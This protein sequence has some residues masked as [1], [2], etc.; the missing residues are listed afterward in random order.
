MAIYERAEAA[1]AAGDI[2]A[3]AEIEVEM[4]VDGIGQPRT[5]VPAWIREAVRE[6]DLPLLRP[7]RVKGRP[8][9][10]RAAGDRAPR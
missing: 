10:A 1:E 5:R 6:M 8:I 3:M 7:D 4:W 2:E 9:P